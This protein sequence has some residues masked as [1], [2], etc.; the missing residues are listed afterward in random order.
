MTRILIV[1]DHRLFAEAVGTALADE[2]Y[3]VVAVAATGAEAVATAR[4]FRPDLVLMELELPD[5]SGVDVGSEILREHPDG[6]VL[7]VS[8]SAD[9]GSIQATVEAGF[10]GYVTKDASIAHLVESLRA[11]AGGEVVIPSSASLGDGSAGN[12]SAGEQHL[13]AALTTREWEIL[14]FLSHG[15]PTREIARRLHIAPNTV[16]S[17]VQALLSK[18]Q[19]HSRLEAVAVARR[20][21]LI[22]D[23]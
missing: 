18:L 6:R 20:N 22:R 23:V 21:R 9:P 10:H 15:L 7:A 2:G 4:L 11:V 17:H 14:G 3:E 13:A 8:D 12:G 1:D 19:V 16:R 5:A